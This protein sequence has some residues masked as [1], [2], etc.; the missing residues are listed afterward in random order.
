MASVD[1]MILL[2]RILPVS[3]IFSR[4]GHREAHG[5]PRALYAWTEIIVQL[6][7]RKRATLKEVMRPANKSSVNDTRTAVKQKALMTPAGRILR[8]DHPGTKLCRED[9]CYISLFPSLVRTSLCW[10]TRT[11]TYVHKYASVRTPRVID[12]VTI[13]KGKG[14]MSV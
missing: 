8:E 5:L 3:R 1:H 9:A 13:S 6:L 10:Y 12:V 11:R 14:E 4:T 7:A 2:L